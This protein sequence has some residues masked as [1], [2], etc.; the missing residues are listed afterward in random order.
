[1]LMSNAEL[2][3]EIARKMSLEPLRYSQ[4]WEDYLLLEEGLLI[5]A[6]DDVLCIGS[7][8]DNALALLLAGARS[9]LA[10]D[11]SA[12]QCAL[13]ELKLAVPYLGGRK[14]TWDVDD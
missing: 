14:K 13:I 12:A 2:H 6:A 5:A 8:G 11:M 7:A 3:N 10:I 4:V 9:V 1:M